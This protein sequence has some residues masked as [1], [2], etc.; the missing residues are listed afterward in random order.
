MNTQKVRFWIVVG[1]V[2][3]LTGTLVLAGCAPQYKVGALRNE[4]RSVDVG[5]AEAVRVAINQGAGDLKLAGGAEKLLEAD[6]NY[7]VARLQPQVKYTKGTLVVQQ[8]GSE[9]LPALPGITG[10]RNDWDLRLNDEVPMDLSVD[11]GGGTS[12]LQLAGLS[13]TGLDISL[14]AG[15]STVDLS[16]DWKRDLD[17]TIDSGAAGVTVRLPENVGVRIRIGSGPHMVDATGMTK[18]GEFYTNAAYGETDVT[19]N[20]VMEAGIGWINLEVGEE[21]AAAPD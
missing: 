19:L 17:V 3:V 13:L 9:G 11:M 12:D 21:A 15:T 20:V 7:N 16:G 8:P 5:N 4:S 18:D 14:G 2:F 6:F 1:L 10:F